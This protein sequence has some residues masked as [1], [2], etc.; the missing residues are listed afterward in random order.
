[1][2]ATEGRVPLVMTAGSAAVVS[3][4]AGAA[5]ALPLWGL[6]GYVIYLYFER[7]P[8]LPAVP[9]GVLSP[10]KGKVEI[11][12]LIDDPWL[13][14]NAYRVRLDVPAPGIGIL[15]SPIEGKVLKLWTDAHPF[16]GPRI[17]GSGSGSPNCYAVQIRTDEGVDVIVAVSSLRPIS[18]LRLNATPGERIG[19]GHRYAFAYFASYIDVL[20]PANAKPLVA[21]TQ[22]VASGT[23][24]LSQLAPSR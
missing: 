18:R 11:V 5:W 23:T 10:V 6:L 17:A 13:N 15:R 21:T 7:R 4:Y 8:G 9:L 1:M 2:I 12:G 16:D 14:R 3:Y 19:Q 22:R 24:V 20:F